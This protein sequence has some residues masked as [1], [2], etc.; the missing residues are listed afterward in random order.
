MLGCPRGVT[1]YLTPADY[2]A[3]TGIYSLV[4]KSLAAGARTAHLPESLIA[5]M[6]AQR[7]NPPNVMRVHDFSTR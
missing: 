4:R 1:W 3:D 2:D 7:R 6:A 5:A